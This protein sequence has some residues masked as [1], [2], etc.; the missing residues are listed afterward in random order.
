MKTY[1]TFGQSHAHANANGDTLDKDCVG[2]LE[3]ES[4][5]SGHEIAMKLFDGK[6]HRAI[7]E[8]DFSFIE[9]M[10]YYPRGVIEVI[11]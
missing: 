8:E 4:N 6:F 3:H 2:C 11:R 7:R 9:H 10:P 5:E 1:I